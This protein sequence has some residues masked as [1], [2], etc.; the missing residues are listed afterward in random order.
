M[1]HCRSLLDGPRSF[2]MSG[3]ATISRLRH[4]TSSAH[5]CRRYG[6]HRGSRR[7]WGTTV[8]ALSVAVPRT[9]FSPA[10]RAPAVRTA[11]PGLSRALRGNG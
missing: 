10:R 2:D 11:A 6:L 1:T 8:A 3:A 7:R 4:S 9:R 5:Q